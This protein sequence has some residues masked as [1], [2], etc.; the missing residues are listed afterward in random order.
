M[1]TSRTNGS[2]SL[3]SAS[4]HGEEDTSRRQIHQL[5]EKEGNNVCA[6]CGATG[7]DTIMRFHMSKVSQVKLVVNGPDLAREK[8]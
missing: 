6:D 7:I 4:D 8:T 1:D 2:T 3:G 5:K